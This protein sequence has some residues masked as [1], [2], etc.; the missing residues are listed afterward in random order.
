ML[1]TS[2]MYFSFQDQFYE[3]VKGVA[4]GS[5]VRPIVAN[6]YMEYFELKALSTAPPP[7]LGRGM[8]MTH[9]SSRRKSTKRISYN[10]L[11]VLTLPSSLQWRTIRRMVPSPSWTSLL[12]QR[13][14]G[15][16]LSLCTGNL[17]TWTST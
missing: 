8:Q 9:F 16:C 4:M 10:T 11:T 6:L 13:L 12:K 15:I 1:R 5:P 2:L 7:G 14:M 3:Q 17:P